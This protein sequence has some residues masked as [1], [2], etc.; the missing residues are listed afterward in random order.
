MFS[1]PHLLSPSTH[2]LPSKQLYCQSNT[3]FPFSF[4][5]SFLSFFLFPKALSFQLFSSPKYTKTLVHCSLYP[6]CYL[7]LRTLYPPNN[8]TANQILAFLSLFLYPF[9]L[10]FF[11]FPK[12]LSFQL[13]S[14]P[15]Y[16]KTLVHCS[17]YPTCY[18][19]L[20]TLYPPNN[21][22][23][24]QIL[25]F[26]SL[27]LYP[28]FL[29]FFLF[30]K[31]LS[32][33]LFSSPKYTKTLVHCSLYPTC[34]LLLRTLYPPN[35]STANQILAFLS[36]FLY[37]FFLSFFLFPKALSFQ[38]F[39]SPKYTKTLVHCSLYPTCY[40]L[41][42]TLYLPNNPTANQILAFLSLFLY[43]FFLS[44]FLFPKALSFQLFSSPKYTKT[45]VHCSLYP[46]CYL[47]LR[48]LYLPNNP[49]ANQIL[50]FLSLFLYPFFLS[51]FLFPKALSFQLFSSPKYTK[52]LVHCSLYPTCYLLLRT[53]YLPNNPTANQ[54]LAFLSLFLYP[55]FLSF[56]L[57]PKALSF[58][59]FSSPKY[60]KTLVHCSLYPTCYLLLRTLYLPNNPTANQ[61]LAFLSLFLYPFFLSFFL[62]PKALSFQLFSSPKY[63]KTLVHCSLYP[64]CYL[65]L[66]T[67]YLPNNPTANQ[68]L[69]FLSLF[70][71]PF[72]LSFFL[73]P[74][75][76]S[77]QLFSSP[78][79]TKTLVHCSL[80]PTCYLLL[81]T[82]YPPNNSTANQIL[83]FLSLFLYPFFLSF[84]L[85]PKALSFQLFSSPKYTKTLVHCS[86]YP[87]CYLLL[88]TLYPPNNSTANQILAFLSLF[89][90]PFFLSFFLFPKALS[91]Q[92]FSSPKYTK[93]LVHCSLYPTCY[94]LLRTLYPPNNST[95]NQILAFLSLFL[96]PFF[97]SFF[98]FPKAL[99][100]QLFSSPKYTKTLVHCSLYPTC[101]LLLR[102]LY[103][104]NNSTA[105]QIL[106]FL[107]L[108]L[109]PF[110]LSFFL[111]PKAL[112]FQLF[113]SPKY[114]KTLV[115]C[116]LYP[117]CY[118]L[119][120]T[121]YPPNNSTANQILA[122]L[123]LFLYPFFLS[124]FLF[125]KALSFQLFSSPKYTKTLVH[126]SLYPTCYLLLRTLYPP[127][128]STANQILAFLSL[129]LY[130]FF[131]SF[132]LF[133]K[134]LSFQLFSSPKYTKTLV[135]CSLYPTCYL[136]LRTLY[137]PNNST[138]NQ[139]LAFLSLF[140][141]PFFLSFFLFP[142]A[143]SFQ[144]FSSPK[145]TKTLVHCSLYP[146]CYL[147]LR[148]LYPPNNSTANQI[149]AFLSL[150]LYPFF[151][152]F[153]LFPKALSFQLFSS[154]K[155]TKT[156]VHC[157]LYPTCYL[158]LRTL[159]LPNN[160][161]ANQILAFLSLFLYPFFLS[162]FLFPKA[163]SFQLFSSPKYTKTL[164]HCSLYPTCYLLLRTLYLPN[165]PTANQI[166][167][168]LSLFLYP[169][170]LSF[171]LFPK[172]LSFQLFSSPKY[173]K[174][175]VHCSLYPTCYLLLRTLYLPNN[176]TANQ[177]L[178][179]LSL[180]LY[181]FF[182]SFFLFP[183][184]LSFQLFSSPKYT[185]TLVHCSL[186]PT[187]YL[188]L[189]TLYLPNNSTANQILAFLSLFLYPFFL[190]FF[191][192]PKALSFQL[193][194]SPKYTKTL[195]HCSL[196][197]TCYLLLRTL[198]LPNNSTANQILAFLSLFLYPFF[199]SFF[200]FP[201]A[202]SFQLFSSPKYTKTLV[203]CSLYP[204]CYLLLRTLYLPNNSTPNQI[205]A[206]LSLFLYP[207]FLSF[208][209]FPKALSFQLFSSPKYTKTL[210]HCSLYPTCYLL[211]RTA[212]LPN[213]STPNQILAFLSL[214]LYPFFLSFFLFPKALS[215]QLFSSPKYT[216]TLVHCSLY[217]T[218]YL[219]LRTAYLPNNST[220]NQIL[221]F[222]SLFL[223]PFFLSFFLFPKK[224]RI[225]EKR[226]ES[227][228]LIGSRV[229][230]RV[231]SA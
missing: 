104:P 102:T 62:F 92:L 94:L 86:L 80:Y 77:F 215:F 192:F 210:V 136:L 221:A 107:S 117:T 33:Q 8:S 190:S 175:L 87:T 69:A 206:F 46:T 151:L 20:R 1:L 135:H 126:C 70:L 150:F 145:Y 93:T 157:S 144:L 138:A 35:N 180:F 218:C 130:P 204:T 200:L 59:L 230:W 211:L 66:R 24:N 202:L 75:A 162:F 161:T 212:Y 105:N 6:T 11:L 23:A 119:L 183:K 108:F 147:L 158:L 32:F 45:L 186:Y 58:Q 26:L 109:Y 224:E 231:E 159:Y 172:A 56:F 114:T 196:Y 164:V 225:K 123:S 100:F 91:F 38:L 111:F 21:S 156:L 115:H 72:F 18:L 43:P 173:T 168:F 29:S 199:L 106:A 124:F 181:P 207:F 189:R 132:F 149:L 226:K 22:T 152:S 101:Y 88:R 97:L 103:P 31:A 219:L 188:L 170:F 79:Y 25:A 182:L 214:F 4:P 98:L 171:F 153:F 143:L 217:P 205:L 134:A 53:L 55:F 13:F 116:S 76:L 2:S 203:H 90:Y 137:L 73:F 27:F 60:T 141:Y 34:Y 209:L 140:L 74:K 177:I 166:L 82:L 64:T 154:P 41:L 227:K 5:L 12:A 9:F 174:T 125:P 139:I 160:P 39:S 121:L 28:F 15:K 89:L 84:F 50:A 47:L 30:P 3:C 65:L 49:T 148:T 184:A 113:S 61:I 208:F 198:Y 178:A 118:L 63:T 163:L 131:L 110:F 127:N 220:P 193:F 129:F 165:N 187:C 194:S 169:F 71:Y 52:T 223:Y 68:I 120:R 78:K 99:S 40:L 216:K 7:L 96:Y 142:K 155:Y 44:F 81:R 14:S 201:K 19:L 42:R 95:A 179:F 57:F 213:N 85:F 191:L 133:P 146:T 51:F 17:L 122:F 128:N 112:S 67:L 83:A 228:Y 185:K 195:V 10:S 36:L 48:T 54:I 197:P 167:A 222:L 16:T 229:V 37:P 176:P